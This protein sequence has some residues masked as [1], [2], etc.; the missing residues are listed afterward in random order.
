MFTLHRAFK[1]WP[2][3]HICSLKGRL[4]GAACLCCCI[5]IHS[6]IICYSGMMNCDRGLS[7]SSENWVWACH[8]S[9]RIGCQAMVV[10]D[11]VANGPPNN[12][13]RDTENAPGDCHLHPGSHAHILRDVQQKD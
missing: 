6:S 4:H 12:S 3:L 1:T 11:K 10:H 9:I 2:L 5:Q 13:A 7:G 8:E